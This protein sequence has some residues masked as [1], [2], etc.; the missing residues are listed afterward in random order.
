MA[1]AGSTGSRSAKPFIAA[2]PENASIRVPKPGLD[3]QGPGLPPTRD[4]DDHELGVAP[5]QHV[6]R[7]ADLFER[8]GTVVLDQHGRVLEQAEQH[9]APG[10]PAQVQAQ[11]LLVARVNLPPERHALGVPVSEIVA[12]AR[13]LDLDHLGAEIGQHVGQD[14]AGDQ[15]REVQHPHVVERAGGVGVEIL[16]LHR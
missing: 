15:A 11:A 3:R 16:R 10:V 12:P 7:E 13:L 4:A 8:A 9:L 2:K 14:V 1:N 5:E 6:G